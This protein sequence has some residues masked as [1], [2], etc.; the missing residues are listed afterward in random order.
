MNLGA[1]K[2]SNTEPEKLQ[3]LVCKFQDIFTLLERELSKTN[4]VKHS[5][6]TET[7]AS[8]QRPYHTPVCWKLKIEDLV[9]DMQEQGA[10]CPSSSPWASP[11]VLVPKKDG[12]GSV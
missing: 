5:I 7:H 10:V 11:V 12:H 4:L 1:L 8:E 2:I 9:E 6:H 3:G